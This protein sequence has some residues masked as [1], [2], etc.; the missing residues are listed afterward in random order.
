MNPS[1]ILA[2]ILAASLLLGG[3]GWKWYLDERE[4]FGIFKGTQEVLAKQQKEANAKEKAK[5]ETDIKLA[6]S[7]RDVALL[8]LRERQRSAGTIGAITAPAPAEGTNKICFARAEFNDALQRFR[9]EIERFSGEFKSVAG[10]GDAAIID[11][12]AW[13]EAWPR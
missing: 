8:K 3:T 10:E 4:A 7:D 1:V 11:T 5:H 2:C 9:Q 6:V 13:S 12:R